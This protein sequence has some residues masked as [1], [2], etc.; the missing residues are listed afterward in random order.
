[1]GL[2]PKHLEEYAAFMGVPRGPKSK[3]FIVDAVH[4]DDGNEGN[5]FA[6][7]LA[8]VTEAETRT[9][10]EHHDCVFLV[11]SDTSDQPT[12]SIA[13]D[14][15]MTHLVGIGPLFNGRGCR[16]QI[17]GT[18]TNGIG[19]EGVIDFSGRGCLVKNIQVQNAKAATSGGVIVSGPYNVFENCYFNG[20]NDSTAGAAATAFCLK[21][22]GAEN[23][24]RNCTIGSC[25]TIR[26]S[27]NAALVISTG[28]NTWEDCLIQGYSQ[29]AG[30]FLVCLTA[31]TAGM[32]LLHFKNC[33]F[34]C[35]TVAWAAGM[36]DVF[37]IA[38]TGS[39]YVMLEN[40]NAIGGTG[41]GISWA[42]VVTHVYHNQAAPATGGG[43]G[44]AVNA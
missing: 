43:I 2:Y 39:H 33:L 14:H 23:Y 8:T 5:S 16:S 3:W 35:Q 22:T 9:T 28:A 44:I 42:D 34:Y 31:G 20:M 12:V 11:A 36:T 25:Q 10:T 4:G 26:A 7:P 13:W 41:A 1:M 21:L 30:N 37:N 27:T 32:S 38:Q 15:H 29:T 40:C 17:V 24:F 19:V 18:A 6:K